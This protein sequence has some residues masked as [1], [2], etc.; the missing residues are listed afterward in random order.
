MSSLMLHEFSGFGGIGLLDKVPHLAFRIAKPCKRAQILNIGEEQRR[1]LDDLRPFVVGHAAGYFFA[2]E[3]DLFVSTV[4][5]WLVTRMTAAAE[6]VLLRRGI[7]PP[8]PV[9]QG[10][11]CRI[12]FDAV[13][14]ERHTAAYEVGAIFGHFDLRASVL[15]IHREFLVGWSVSRCEA[16]TEMTRA[17]QFVDHG[18]CKVLH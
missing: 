17:L 7:S 6:S 18:D 2:D 15:F 12:C 16:L 11:A 13:F 9:V 10:L 4:A 1:P 5:K 14:T 8:L 3:G